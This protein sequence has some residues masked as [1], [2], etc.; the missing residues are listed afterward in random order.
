L[1]LVTNAVTVTTGRNRW[2]PRGSEGSSSSRRR[3]LLRGCNSTC[4]LSVVRNK[5]L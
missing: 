4:A 1:V 5:I 3:K 2:N